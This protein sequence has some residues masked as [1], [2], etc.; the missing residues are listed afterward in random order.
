MFLFEDTIKEL[1]DFSISDIILFDDVSSI[2]LH[3]DEDLDG[4]YPILVEGTVNKYVLPE[5]EVQ[6][7]IDKLKKCSIIRLN[8]HCK[9][10][11]F[12]KKANLTLNDC[13]GIIHSLNTVDYFACIKSINSNHLN[14]ALIIFK[15][16]L[17]TL[18]DGRTFSKIFSN[19]TVYLKI[20]LD[21]IA[22]D[23]IALV[24]IH[25]GSRGALP[26]ATEI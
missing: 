22:R 25:K 15:P 6:T 1:N 14:N 24:S 9:V 7:I 17:V 13:L 19:L 21:E 3:S 4:A 2:D 16:E 8:D 11:N 18:S 10:N 5:P 20:D 26:Y 12:L 23:A